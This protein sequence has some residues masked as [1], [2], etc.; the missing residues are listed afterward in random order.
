MVQ[1]SLFPFCSPALLVH[2]KDD[3]YQMCMDYCALNKIT[4]KNKS[5][6]PRIE[7]L[8]DKFQGSIYFIRIDLQS[9]YHQIKIMPQGIHKKVFCTTFGLYEYLVMSFGLNNAPTTFYQIME[10]LFRPQYDFTRVFFD[11]IIKQ[12]KSMEEHKVHFQVIF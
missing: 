3:T 9:G 12:L 10:T 1:S 11:K 7:D 8:F 4:I 2:K 5:L 6:L